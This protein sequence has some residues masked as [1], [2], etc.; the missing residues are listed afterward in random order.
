[1]TDA[2]RPAS[3]PLPVTSEL[4][5]RLA[6][7]RPDAGPHRFDGVWWPRS[8][9]LGHGLPGLLSVLEDR[10]PG[11]TRVTVSRAMWRIR[12]RTLLLNGRVVHINRSAATPRP[13]T[14]CLLSYGVGRCDLLVVAPGTTPARARDIMDDVAAADEMRQVAS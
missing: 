7:S 9:D 5:P 11:I 14:I 8:H 10:W 12:P 1:M 4:P 3:R 6:M 2:G 13:N